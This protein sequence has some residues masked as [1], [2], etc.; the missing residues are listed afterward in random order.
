[1]NSPAA[2]CEELDTLGCTM[3][4]VFFSPMDTLDKCYASDD[5]VD[6]M[7]RLEEAALDRNSSAYSIRAQSKVRSLRYLRLQFASEFLTTYQNCREV[8]VPTWFEVSRI[9]DEDT[10]WLVAI[11]EFGQDETRSIP[12]VLAQTSAAI[13]LALSLQ[14]SEYK[15][16]LL[17]EDLAAS[18]SAFSNLQGG[19]VVDVSAIKS[20]HQRILTTLI[21][22]P[23]LYTWVSIFIARLDYCL[24]EKCRGDHASVKTFAMA[25]RLAM[26]CVILMDPSVER[27]N[28]TI[29][30]YCVCVASVSMGLVPESLFRAWRTSESEQRHLLGA[31][32]I[33]VSFNMTMKKVSTCIA[34]VGN[35]LNP[36]DSP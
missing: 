22:A 9:C 28:R 17:F 21:A 1:M 23:S 14:S 18:A 16:T 11:A 24:L 10:P 36:I 19:H 15:S 20:H 32:A 30:V 6:A 12:E 31:K 7:Q 8:V 13:H 25:L 27:R 5:T 26:R 2:M 3:E 34:D 33:C 35:A 4:R 29:A